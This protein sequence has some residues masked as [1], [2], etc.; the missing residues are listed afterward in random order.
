MVAKP[1]VPETPQMPLTPKVPQVPRTL[2]TPQ[3][4][5][6]PEFAVMNAKPR[7]LKTRLPPKTP[8]RLDPSAPV[9]GRDGREVAGRWVVEVQVG[10]RMDLRRGGHRSLAGSQGTAATLRCCKLLKTLLSPK[11]PQRLDPSAPVEGREGRAVAGRHLRRGGRRSLAGSQRTAATSRC[12][13]LRLHH[14]VK[15]SSPDTG[16]RELTGL[17]SRKGAARV[18]ATSAKR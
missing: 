4:P 15:E 7:V 17:L 10:H 13:K 14:G 12:C 8:Q 9:E 18:P 1:R 3:V 5:R 16:A 11:T 6:T 2:K